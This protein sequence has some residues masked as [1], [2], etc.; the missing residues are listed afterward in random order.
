MQFCT[1]FQTSCTRRFELLIRQFSIGLLQHKLQRLSQTRA[2]GT[3]EDPL[4]YKRAALSAFQ[5]R[6]ALI[7]RVQLHKSVGAKFNPSGDV[8]AVVTSDGQL[9]YLDARLKPLA[10]Y[11]NPYMSAS[12]AKELGTAPCMISLEAGDDNCQVS[13][14]NMAW[15]G[16][17][18]TNVKL[19]SMCSHCKHVW[20]FRAVHVH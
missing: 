13:L 3:E 9:Q 20:M 1:F 11:T 16:C 10:S 4:A 7:W 5:S 15:L 18:L 6:A 8:Q 12:E 2:L 19:T 17:V 14:L